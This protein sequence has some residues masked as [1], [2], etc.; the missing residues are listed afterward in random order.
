MSV[1]HHLDLGPL[2]APTRVTAATG[3]LAALVATPPAGVPLRTPVLA[4]PGYTGSKEDF[5]HLLPLL[6]EAGH[7]ATAID[8]R[9]QY[10]SGGPNDP[11]A[12][13]IDA[14]A[15][16]VIA[17]L[18]SDQ[19]HHLIGHSFGGLICR[20][21]VIRHACVLSLVLLGSGPAA[22]GGPRGQIIELMRPLLEAGGVPAVFEASEAIDATDP[23][24]A[25]LPDDVKDFLR[26]RFL[27]SPDAALLGMGVAVTT[28]AD[29]V[30]ALRATGVPAL[31]AHGDADDAWTPAE[32]LDMANRLQARYAVI[33]GAGHS[34]AVDDPGQV[35]A[36]LEEFW[37]N[38]ENE[39]A[40]PR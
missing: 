7:P 35:A 16:D 15:T 33:S 21:S 5:L 39:T 11:A 30:A 23:R 22:L 20:A 28:A 1:P 4:V 8:L 6:A 27:A 3:E 14:L 17:L 9:G 10:E 29:Q 19:P 40:L 24:K 26:R 36:V 32:Q 18:P 38:C 13:S 37:A 25:A 12:Y 31:V 34:P 2:V